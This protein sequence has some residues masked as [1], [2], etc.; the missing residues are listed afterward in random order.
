MSKIL[1]SGSVAYDYIMKFD[2]QFSDHILKDQLEKLN[3]GFTISH[4]Q[5]S[6]GWTAHNIAYSLW[7]LGLKEETMMLAA[8][9][10]DFV[11]DA[12]LADCIDYQYTLKDPDLFTACAYIITDAHNNQ[13]TNFYPGAMMK[14]VDQHIPGWDIAYAMIAPNA[15][16]AMLMQLQE[17][18][19]NQIPCFFDPGQALGLF[20]KD[21]LFTALKTADYLICNEYEFN[22]I[23]E[24][25]WLPK[26]ELIDLIS[27]AVVTL[28]KNGAKLFAKSFETLI[29]GVVVE[30]VVDPTWAGDSFRSWLLA[31]LL[32]QLSFEDASKIGNVVASFAVAAQ[33]TLEHA[34]TKQDVKDKIHEVYNQYLEF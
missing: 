10:K 8:V 28:W 9:G 14:S 20:D 31:G 27:I 33:G 12:K 32:A 3:V 19:K 2:G 25:T 22:A 23:L 17:C 30:H 15:K 16:D 11:P 6:S 21:D 4:I 26:D 29:P 18:K 24:K 34:F 5:K 13:I 7:L 1:V